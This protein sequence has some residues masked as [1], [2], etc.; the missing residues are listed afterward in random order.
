MIFNVFITL[1]VFT[2]VICEET[3]SASNFE[4]TLSGCLIHNDVFKCLKIQAVKVANRALSLK[5]F[6]IMD[7]VSFVSVDRE[8]KALRPKL[9]LNDS[10]LEKLNPEQLDDLLSETS[11]R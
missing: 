1:L 3:K 4:K 5:K 2:L 6:D 11:S 8:T 9:Y 7:G 10:K